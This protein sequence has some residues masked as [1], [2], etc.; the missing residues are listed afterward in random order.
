MQPLQGS[1]V[2]HTGRLGL[3]AQVGTYGHHRLVRMQRKRFMDLQN[4]CENKRKR[5]TSPQIPPH[6]DVDNYLASRLFLR[7]QIHTPH[8]ITQDNSTLK[9]PTIHETCRHE[10]TEELEIKRSVMN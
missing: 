10:A 1:F 5:F 3:A 4:D 2:L 7:S 6:I 8:A 9:V